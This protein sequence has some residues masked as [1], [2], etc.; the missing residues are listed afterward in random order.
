M[1][2]KNFLSIFFLL[3]LFVNCSGKFVEVPPAAN[4]LNFDEKEPHAQFTA[5]LQNYVKDGKVNYT[6]LCKD[7]RLDTYIS[8]LSATNPETISNANDKLA[9]WLNAY[10]AFTL[11]VI[12]D[13]YPVKSIN[14]LHFGGLAI[15]YVLKKTIW[16]KKFVN[17]NGKSISLNYIEHKIIRASRKNPNAPFSEICLETPCPRAHF[18]LVCASIGCPDLRLEAYE[19][20]KLDEQLTDQAVQFFNDTDKYYFDADNKQAHLSKI[21][22]WF[23]SDFGQ[24]D[25]EILLFVAQYIPD[26]IAQKIRQNPGE[27]EIK[28]TDYD[29]NLNE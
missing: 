2:Y 13:N 25:E 10:N 7:T 15:G 26:G 29:W 28:H 4:G 1:I 27:W 16:D 24:T 9:F 12:C 3:L 22:D 23:D 20:D 11:K 17:I 14:D 5:I 6:A 21:L 8:R 18:A 19:G